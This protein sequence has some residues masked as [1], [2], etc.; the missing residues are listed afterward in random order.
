MEQANGNPPREAQPLPDR[1]LLHA[2]CA[3]CSIACVDDLRESGVEPTAFWY[4]PNIHPFTE[5]RQRRNTLREYASSIG[6]ALAERDEYGLRAFLQEVDGAFDARCPVCY[7]MR[8]DAAAAY[9][10]EHGFPAFSTTLLI[11]PYQN[12]ALLIEA[13]ERAASRYG[14]PF[15]YRDFRPRF[16]EGQDRAR[17]LGLYM[18]KYCGCIF[19]EEDRYR[20]RKKK[21]A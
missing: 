20:K 6:M 12:H 2:C 3:P 14:V 17:E 13:G 9:A 15:L 18:Q 11:S 1:V 4:N 8:L 19:S 10:A 5:Y 7:R 21:Q 16:R